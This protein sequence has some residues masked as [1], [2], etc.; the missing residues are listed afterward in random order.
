MAANLS[1]L[2]T[3][4]STKCSGV[5][6]G[7]VW[8]GNSSEKGKS[9]HTY[10]ITLGLIVQVFSG[11]G[12]TQLALQLSLL[13][14]LPVDQGGLNGSA[15]YLTTSASL[16][17]PRL[18]QLLH[19]HPLLSGSRCTLDNIQTSATKS[20]SSLLHALSDIIPASINAAKGR[21]APLKL[22][23]I[24]SLADLLMEDAKISTAT[25]ADRSRNLS[26]IAAQLHALASTHQLAVVAINRVTDVWERRPDA[27]MGLPGELLYADHARLFG[28]ASERDGAPS[29]KSAALGLVW[30]NQVNARIMLA[31]TERRHNYYDY[32]YGHHTHSLRHHHG[33]PPV[34]VVAAAAAATATA[35]PS[36]SRHDRKRQRLN[37]DE[38]DVVQVVVVRQLTVVFSSVCA[39]ASVDFIVTSRGV[40]M[41]VEDLENAPA[42]APAH[43]PPTTLTNVST[44]HAAAAASSEGQVGRPPRPP[45]AEV[46]PLDVGSV[47]GD[48]RPPQSQPQPTETSGGDMVEDED[49]YWREVDDF[50][51]ST[52]N[53]DVVPGTSPS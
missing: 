41:L 39:P 7:S 45:L 23:I 16:P 10:I 22:L 34:A 38:G 32:R 40:E 36:E 12:K 14:Q 6:S 24:D 49:D 4:Y 35:L 21:P 37:E 3:Q 25:L 50:P 26:A 9:S 42:P 43:A 20:V 30:A 29:K 17:T 28:R 53:I 8:S 19:E 33:A 48:F 31:R 18:I 47:V 5:V 15:C 46:S 13:V 1:R 11:A 27:D 51:F 2:V 52:D 44:I